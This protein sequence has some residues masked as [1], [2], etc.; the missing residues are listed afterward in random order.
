LKSDVAKGQRFYPLE[1]KA[2]IY[3]NPPT[4]AGCKIEIS[5]QIIGAIED[6]KGYNPTCFPN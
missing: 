4:A 5:D 2:E 1:F 6:N 3:D